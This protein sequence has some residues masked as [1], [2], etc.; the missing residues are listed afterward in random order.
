MR[1]FVEQYPELATGSGCTAA[2]NPTYPSEDP[3]GWISG[4]RYAI[5]QMPVLV[6]LENYRTGFIWKLMRGNETFRR[7]LRRAGFEGGWLEEAA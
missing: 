2:V 5:N 3:R 7:G 6:M 4:T 1:H